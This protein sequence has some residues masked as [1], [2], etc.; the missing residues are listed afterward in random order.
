MLYL[1][2]MSILASLAALIILF[3]FHMSM[4]D[5]GLCLIGKR[6]FYLDDGVR[7]VKWCVLYVPVYT[8]EGAHSTAFFPE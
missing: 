7:L 8:Y 1:I 6:E 3:I 5:Q 2:P 4:R